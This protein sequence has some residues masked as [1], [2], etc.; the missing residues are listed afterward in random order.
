M[1]ARTLACSLLLL[2]GCRTAPVE[3]T[4]PEHD[5]PRPVLEVLGVEPVEGGHRVQVRL[6]NPTPST[7]CLQALRGGPVVFVQAPGDDGSGWQNVTNPMWCGTD[8]VWTELAPGAS[9]ES[10]VFVERGLPKVRLSL[11]VLE[12]VMAPR[13][14]YHGLWPPM[15]QP[16]VRVHT[17]PIEVGR[18]QA[19]R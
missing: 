15:G 9:L 11:G 2:A 4:E 3:T 5:G 12:G 16:R 7:W 19:V 17:A 13:E 1:R 18:L 6:S 14:G 8:I 10:L